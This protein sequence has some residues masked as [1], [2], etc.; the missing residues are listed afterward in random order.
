V[1]SL[2]D[3]HAELESILGPAIECFEAAEVVE[4]LRQMW[5]PDRVRVVLLAE[6]HVWT[7]RDEA[8]SRV[9]QPDGVETGFARFIYCLGG[10]EPQIVSPT[11]QPNAG[12]AQYWKLL[13]D[14]MYG[15]SQPHSGLLKSGE[16]RS[17]K[18]LE[19]KLALLRELR[20][21][22]IWLVDAS[23]TALYHAGRRVTGQPYERVLRTCWDFYVGDAVRSAAPAAV[24]VIGQCVNGVLG[25]TIRKDLDGAVRLAVVGQPNAWRSAPQLIQYRQQVFD[26]CQGVA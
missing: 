23:I 25:E 19:N 17:G 14:A 3:A 18:R 11:V 7:S 8:R 1:T 2:Q 13:H 20:S 21:S 22:G 6:S 4:Q 26:L 9:V 10:G 24:I 16:P 15:P 5:R 12:A